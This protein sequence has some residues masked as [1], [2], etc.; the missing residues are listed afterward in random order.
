M[1]ITL[2]NV[3]YSPDQFVITRPFCVWLSSGHPAY[4][5]RLE[6]YGMEIQQR[7]SNGLYHKILEHRKRSRLHNGLSGEPSECCRSSNKYD[8]LSSQRHTVPTASPRLQRPRIRYGTLLHATVFTKF[9]PNVSQLS[10]QT[11]A[12][13]YA[14]FSSRAV[15]AALLQKKSQHEQATNTRLT[16][17]PPTSTVLALGP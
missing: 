10:C 15:V 3:T 17:N 2:W 12:N 16:I 5:W 4:C 7:R 8:T 6:W 9:M 11:C 13:S 14:S 1:I